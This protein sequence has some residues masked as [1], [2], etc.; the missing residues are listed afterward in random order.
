MLKKSLSSLV[1]AV[2]LLSLFFPPASCPAELP[3]SLIG[4]LR[5]E[6]PNRMVEGLEGFLQGMEVPP[7]LAA[8]VKLGLGAMVENPGLTGVDLSGPIVLASFQPDQDEAWAACLTL[9]SPE[10]YQRALAK[11]WE[12]KPSDQKAGF[13]VYRRQVKEFDSAAYRSATPEEREDVDSFYRT[14][15][16]I[17]AVAWKEK[18]AWISPQPEVL[19]EVASLSPADF[20]APVD[21]ELVTGMRVPPLLEIA[22]VALR[23]RMIAPVVSPPGPTSPL[24]P[25]AVQ[26]QALAYLDFYFYYARQVENFIFGLTLDGSGVRMEEM[27]QSRPE[28]GLAKFLSAQK[29]GKLSLARFLDPA[30]WLAAS[31]RINDPEMLTDVY[32]RLFDVFSRTMTEMGEAGP[33]PETSREL[34]ALWRSYIPLMD[35]YLTK[36]VG[37]EMA[38]SISSSPGCLIS[39]VSL[40]KIRSREAYRDYIKK[41]FLSNRELLSP[42]Y[43]RLGISVD[44]SGIEEPEKFQGID[45]YT[46][47]MT[48]DFQKLFRGKGI[49]AEQK[50]I[51][52]LMESPFVIQMAATGDLAVTEM[53]WGGKS[54]IKER[55]E[56]IAAGKSSFDTGQLGESWEESNGAIYFSL[57]RY[58]SDFLEPMIERAE[59]GAESEETVEIIKAL[60]KLDLPLITYLNVEGSDLKATLDIP[61]ERILAVKTV[62]ETIR[63]KNR[64]PEALRKK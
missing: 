55:L 49:P 17:L 12:L 43:A 14:R 24:D 11:N 26:A 29:G 39:G 30:P 16:K 23:E 19:R 40:Q 53:S 27:L 59:V 36:C 31:G 61:M 6:N 37:E 8:G 3:P 44:D 62:I 1:G 52:A 50:E 10:A 58:L 34:D 32:A 54:D 64:Q 41:S 60:G 9:S 4:Y 42:F 35:D 38:F 15:E 18:S 51:F 20:P 5:V 63:A 22:E 2:V 33:E 57:N 46:L 13:R 56:Q 47:R 48:L 28:T 25:Q 45:I 7:L 21:G